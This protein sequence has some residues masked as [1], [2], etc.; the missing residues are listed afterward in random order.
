MV[1]TSTST[2]AVTLPTGTTARIVIDHLSDLLRSATAHLDR[3]Q[4]TDDDY[5]KPEPYLTLTQET[6]DELE[7][8]VR[9]EADAFVARFPDTSAWVDR[10]RTTLTIARAPGGGCQQLELA[11]LATLTE[12]A[13]RFDPE[14]AGRAA[15][16]VFSDDGLTVAV[17]AQSASGGDAEQNYLAAVCAL[18]DYRRERR[19]SLAVAERIAVRVAYA[20]LD[21]GARVADM[22]PH[23][24]TSGFRDI[25]TYASITD[26]GEGHLDGTC[27]VPERLRGVIV[28]VEH[29]E[30]GVDRSREA[31]EPY[32]IPSPRTVA[33]VRLHAGRAAPTSSYIGR[34]LID[35]TADDSLIKTTRT[36]AAAAS[37][38]LADGLAEVKFSV[39]R[40]TAVQAIGLLSA[41]AREVRRD[42]HTQVLAAA[43][44]INT[45]IIDD[46]PAT[47]AEHGEP[48]QLTD[49]EAI[50]LLGIDITEAAGFDKVTWDG[51]ADTY[52]SQ[53]I[54]DQL[55]AP[56]ALALVHRA[57]ERGLLTYFSAGFRFG[58]IPDAVATAVDGIGIG[59]AQILRLM[60]KT[61]GN[62]GPFLH[63]NIEE[64]LAVRDRAAGTLRGRCARLLARLDRLFFEGALSHD[65]DVQRQALFTALHTGN[66]EAAQFVLDAH[67]EIAQTAADTVHPLVAWA[68]RLL[69]GPN[70]VARERVGANEWSLFVDTVSR[71]RR[72]GDLD[73][74][75]VMLPRAS[76]R[77]RQH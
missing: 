67:T 65:T 12:H 20:L 32:R 49:R 8:R 52:P 43:F 21:A 71:S 63:D 5:I 37:A 60:D 2:A 16:A 59:G 55:G 27:T 44:P 4:H 18:I 66:W 36:F 48:V 1:A 69:R 68:G 14:P 26:P 42:R 46:R 31:L 75:A 73:Q 6:V 17:R 23:W 33:R 9:R 53:C 38:L 13:V 50:G 19:E 47:V 10:I 76:S 39:E 61:T 30:R 70:D 28:H 57:H 58:N 54:I 64:I 77:Q 41:L 22:H 25:Q 34:P 3:Q 74:L 40:L 24:G 11:Y 15:D 7:A 35:G 51:T 56:A 45:P 29:L 62:H 72:L